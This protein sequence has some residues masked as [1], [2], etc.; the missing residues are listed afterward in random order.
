MH[1]GR[2]RS[3]LLGTSARFGPLGSYIVVGH[4]TAMSLLSVLI[5][6][7]PKKEP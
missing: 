6:K 2:H 4:V 5:V 3:Q 7:A 1:G